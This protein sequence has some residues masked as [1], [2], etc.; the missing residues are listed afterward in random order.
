MQ[1]KIREYFEA[2]YKRT[3]SYLQKHRYE[4][5]NVAWYARQRC[6]GVAQFTQE[7]C[8]VPYEIIEPLYNE[9]A[10]KFQKLIDI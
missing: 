6:L 5:S 7:F 4:S 1:N 10:E 3:E 8:N 2:E 9:Y